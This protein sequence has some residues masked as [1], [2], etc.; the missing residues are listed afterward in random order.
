MR[1]PQRFFGYRFTVQ[2]AIFKDDGSVTI[3]HG[4][5]EMGQG[6]NTKVAQVAAKEL[7]IPLEMI[8]I[9]TTDS[10]IANNNTNTGGSFGSELCAAVSATF[11]TFSPLLSE[12]ISLWVSF[13][14]GIGLM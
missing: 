10:F 11:V 12:L 14:G 7:G 3:S 13:V 5:I 9:R 4:G 8:N 2:A 6:L 1:W